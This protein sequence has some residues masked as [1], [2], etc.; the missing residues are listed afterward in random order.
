M[1]DERGTL[2]SRIRFWVSTGTAI[3]AVALAVP[4]A[5][6]AEGTPSR[7]TVPTQSQPRR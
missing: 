5:A 4:M 2:M 3:A 7:P 6:T 1:T